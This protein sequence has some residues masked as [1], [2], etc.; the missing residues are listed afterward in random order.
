[1]A[2]AAMYFFNRR[3]SLVG[4]GLMAL[5]VACQAPSGSRIPALSLP[6]ATVAIESLRQPQ[7]VERSLPLMGTVTQ[8]IAI[9]N[10]WLYQLD[11]GTGQVWVVSQQPSPAVG[12]QVYVDGI[13]RYE[14]IVING[15]DLG[16][17][18]LEE[19]Q[20]QLSDTNPE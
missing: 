11:D 14:A 13:L 18:Y 16:D 3:F 2:A 17:Y 9:L 5:C 7:R 8:R 15:S 4:M 10:G 12:T 6:R 20:R 19:T 1:M